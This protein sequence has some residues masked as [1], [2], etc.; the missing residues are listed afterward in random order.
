M[1]LTARVATAYR[2][3]VR[4][5]EFASPVADLAVRLWVAHVFWQAGLTKI[6]SMYS[7]I[8][9][10]TYVYHVPLLP[11]E[12]A[13]YLGT[14]VE[15]ILPVLLAFGLAGRL[16]A[17]ILFVYNIVA[18]ISYPG[19]GADG[20]Q[21]HIMWGIMLLVT[22]LHGPGTLSLD[23]LLARL[24]RRWRDRGPQADGATAVR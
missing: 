19:L 1:V 22:F 11:P 9:L 13:A 12:V 6:Q 3:S 8:G 15:L 23:C 18:V 24:F 2:E 7:T 21:L 16:S 5:L 4:W 10:F 20:V 14:G 17:G